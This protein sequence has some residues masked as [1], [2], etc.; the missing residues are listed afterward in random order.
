MNEMASISNTDFIFQDKGANFFTKILE[1][2]KRENPTVHPQIIQYV[3]QKNYC[4]FL[5]GTFHNLDEVSVS[6]R[7]LAHD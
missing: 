4:T 5:T 1:D 2:T 3:Y 6:Q 7:F